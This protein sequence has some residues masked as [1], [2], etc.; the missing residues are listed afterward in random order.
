[1]K[2]FAKGDIVVVLPGAQLSICTG[3][4]GTVRC[5]ASKTKAM[6]EV[7]LEGLGAWGNP[8]FFFDWE[9]EKLKEK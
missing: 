9:I 7:N 6:Y 4:K 1:M 8:W 5:L 3:L 2:T